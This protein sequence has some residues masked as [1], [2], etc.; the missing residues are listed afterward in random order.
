MDLSNDVRLQ[1]IAND[2]ERIVSKEYI[3]TSIFDRINSS[4]DPLP[5]EASRESLPYVVVMPSGAEEISEILRYANTIDIPVYIRGSG[6]SFTGASRPHMPGIVINTRRLNEIE[7]LEDY[8]Y[9]ECGAGCRVAEV[10]E[11]LDK[12]GY[13]L[14]VVPGSRRVAS[15]GGIMANNTS[16]HVIDASIG[17]PADY[18]LGLQ[19]V[20]PTGEIIETGTKGLRKPAGTDLTTFFVGKDGIMGVVTRIRMRLVPAYKKAYGYAVFD[21]LIKLARGVKRM[22]VEKKPAPLFME[23]MD[24]ETTRIGFEIKGMEPPKGA[25]IFF[26]GIGCTK[27]EAEKKMELVLASFKA[28]K[29]VVAES[30]KDMHV[31]ETMWSSREVIGSYLSQTSKK[32][33]LSA[34]VVANLH[35]LVDCM[36]DA[37]DFHKGLPTLSQLSHYLFGHI[38]ALTLHPLYLIPPDWS[39][40]L[41][42]KAIE[43]KFRREMELNIKYGTCGGEWGQLSKRTPFFKNRYGEAGYEMIKAI[44]KALDPK[45]ILN[46]G[47]LEGYR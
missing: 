7:I 33:P 20:L 3:S 39:E 36:R 29:P 27:E 22:Y 24:E 9:F 30:V 46:R 14:P 32:K 13:F 38:G 11:E 12:R 45:N 47:V 10:S 34:E 42:K 25:I 5:Y 2:L 21:D 44:K 16:G 8:G 31:W 23:F 43:E 41:K 28:E 4:I 37:M 18:V 19:A 6:T 35:E 40:E 26:V 1:R 17:K 15:M